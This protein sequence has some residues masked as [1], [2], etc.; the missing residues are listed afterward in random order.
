M[1]FGEISSNNFKVDYHKNKYQT[2]DFYD[3]C[4]NYFSHKVFF[5]SSIFPY[6]EKYDKDSWWTSQLIHFIKA[7]KYYKNKI[8]QFND[9][10]VANTGHSDYP[11]GTEIFNK[12]VEE[13]VQALGGISMSEPA[14]FNKFQEYKKIRK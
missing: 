3:A 11:R 7:N 13:Q 4:C 5:D 14:G 8:V 9:F 1:R 6:D 10:S 12:A 2:V